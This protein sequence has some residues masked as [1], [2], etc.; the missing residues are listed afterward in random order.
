MTK[1]ISIL[2]CIA[3]LAAVLFACSKP[4][5]SEPTS[6][7]QIIYKAEAVSWSDYSEVIALDA[8]V[9]DVSGNIYTISGDKPVI[10]SSGGGTY[11]VSGYS[12]MCLANDGETVLLLAANL[13]LETVLFE[14]DA[15]NATFKT[16]EILPLIALKAYSGSGGFN[17]LLD[18][19]TKLFGYNYGEEPVKILTWASSGIASKNV[20]GV[21]IFDAET[22]LVNSGDE[23]YRLTS[24][25]AEISEKNTT[26]ANL[27]WEKQCDC[28]N[29]NYFQRD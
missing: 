24:E 29:G 13:S 17:V 20:R 11:S 6:T 1:L 10:N 7:T 4:Q 23:L 9:R 14:F 19:G 3:L 21:Q 25:I 26:Y 22:I 12:P 2:V 8:P 18:T 15:K 5:I 28:G 27:L 16:P